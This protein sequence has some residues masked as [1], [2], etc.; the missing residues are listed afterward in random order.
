MLGKIKGRER[1]KAK[2][3]EAAEDEMVR[4]HRWAK[5]HEFGQI[6]GE[7]GGQ[8]SQICC[9]SWAGKESDTTERLKTTTTSPFTQD[10]TQLLGSTA[11]GRLWYSNLLLGLSRP[12]PCTYATQNCYAVCSSSLLPLFVRFYRENPPCLSPHLVMFKS[13]PW[14]AF[15]TSTSELLR[16]FVYH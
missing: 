1:L 16:P 7:S 15:L 11:D 14:E 5:G 12:H 10:K 9:S 3:K 8:R 2:E 4:D 6:P 13:L